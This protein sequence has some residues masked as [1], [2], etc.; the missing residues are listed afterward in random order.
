MSELPWPEIN[1]ELHHQGKAGLCRDSRLDKRG[2]LS[3]QEGRKEQGREAESRAQTGHSDL[4]LPETLA[5]LE[6]ASC[7]PHAASLASATEIPAASS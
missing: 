2:S 3:L 7:L 1:F 6:R 5:A 4:R